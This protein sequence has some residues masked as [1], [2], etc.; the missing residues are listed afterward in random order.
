[1]CTPSQTEGDLLEDV[2]LGVV[3]LHVTDLQLGAGR[4]LTDAVEASGELTAWLHL[5]GGARR[6]FQE[7]ADGVI[8]DRFER[9]AGI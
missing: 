5:D 8:L 3:H 2:T 7:Q 9:I 4:G 1:M 6:L